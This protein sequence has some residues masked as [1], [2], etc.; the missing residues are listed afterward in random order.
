LGEIQIQTSLNQLEIFLKD[1]NLIV[2]SNRGPIEFFY[3]DND[4]IGIKTGAGGIVPTLV[5]VLE[6]VGGIWVASAMSSADIEMASKYPKNKI[7]IPLENPKFHVPLLTLN[8]KK[9]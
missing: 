7:P 4:E 5:P 9:I 1:K 8:K 3:E 6:N 2:A